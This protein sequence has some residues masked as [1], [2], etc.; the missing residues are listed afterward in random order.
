MPIKTV[1]Y[2]DPL[3]MSFLSHTSA[4]FVRKECDCES[5]SL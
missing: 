1:E 2:F 4:T 5:L 3:R